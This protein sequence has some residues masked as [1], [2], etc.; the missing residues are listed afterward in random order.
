MAVGT[1]LLWRLVQYISNVDK[2]YNDESTIFKQ[3]HRNWSLN[4]AFNTFYRV[5][6]LHFKSNFHENQTF[7]VN[8][9]I[10]VWQLSP[11]YTSNYSKATKSI[12]NWLQCK[13]PVF[14]YIDIIL[15]FFA[16]LVGM[17]MG[18]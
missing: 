18:R 11:K 16:N 12:A 17:S 2:V 3:G 6:F 15:L 5:L 7:T 10:I 1:I 14:Y 8:R 4:A 9:G 13:R